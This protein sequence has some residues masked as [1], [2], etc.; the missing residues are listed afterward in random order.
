ML[1]RSDDENFDKIVSSIFKRYG[2]QNI[3]DFK[4]YLYSFDVD[5]EF[6]KEKVLIETLWNELIYSKFNSQVI[7]DKEK[8]KN[9]IKN[10]NKK[11]IMTFHLSE[12]VF[13]TSDSISVNEKYDL[14]KK[15]ISEKNFENAAL[16]YSISN[17]SNQGGNLGWVKEDLI[18]KK[19]RDEMIKLN[20]GELSKPIIIPGGVL[21]LKV[22]DLKEVK[23]EINLTEK[24]NELIRYSTNEQLNQFSN[25]YFNKVKKNIKINEL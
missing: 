21:I 19:L 9:K 7:I 15:E 16:I 10:D 18:S 4:K 23:N 8:L 1:F 12:I 2:H 22:K 6:F 25:I 5:F 17:T 11:T 13:E 20:I 24:L 14:I 3:E